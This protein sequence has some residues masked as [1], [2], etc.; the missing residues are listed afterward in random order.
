MFHGNFTFWMYLIFYGTMYSRTL[1]LLL[2]MFVVMMCVCVWLLLM[3]HHS[4]FYY[5]LMT[6]NTDITH[7]NILPNYDKKYLI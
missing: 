3:V 5:I 4:F 7:Y 2:S 6:V 1:D